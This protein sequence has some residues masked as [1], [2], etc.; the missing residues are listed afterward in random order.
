[1]AKK[2]SRNERI[3][4]D[5]ATGL[6]ITGGVTWG[7]VGLNDF[8]LVTWLIEDTF[9]LSTA[10]TNGVYIAVGV[11]SLPRAWYFLKRLFG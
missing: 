6:L 11:A 9:G 7:L 1:M 4:N 5:V 8:N 10:W 2:M 3:I